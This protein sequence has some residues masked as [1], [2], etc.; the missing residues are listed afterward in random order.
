MPP[1]RKHESVIEYVTRL[2]PFMR[3]EH[4]EIEILPGAARGGNYADV[5]TIDGRR[6]ARIGL[7]AEWEELDPEDERLY[8]VHEMLHI[9]QA[10]MSSFVTEGLGDHMAPPALAVL[11][12]GFN[13]QLEYMTDTLSHVVAPHLPLR[14]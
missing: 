14:Q 2:Q 4:W 7:C 13:R 1:R 9:H 8:L 12:D 5:H 11:V 6:W 3:L 10:M